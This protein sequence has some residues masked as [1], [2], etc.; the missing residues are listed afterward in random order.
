MIG[1][2]YEW[3]KNESLVFPKCLIL[4]KEFRDSMFNNYFITTFANTK[5][6]DIDD[7][8]QFI[9]NLRC[10]DKSDLEED[11]DYMDLDCYGS[12]LHS[13]DKPEAIFKIADR[14][15]GFVTSSW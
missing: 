14:F 6:E 3:L 1:K 13:D 2:D 12:G 9:C 7:D 11:L 15:G 10:L 4:P 5:N 8:Y